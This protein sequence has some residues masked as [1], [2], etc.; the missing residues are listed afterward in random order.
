MLVPLSLSQCFPWGFK[1]GQGTSFGSGLLGTQV[2]WHILLLSIE[3]L[4][5]FSLSLTDNCHNSSN[6]LPY[7]FSVKKMTKIR[8]CA[9][10]R[11]VAQKDEQHSSN[12]TP[13]R[14]SQM[15]IARQIAIASVT[16]V[17]LA[18]SCCTVQYFLHVASQ[19]KNLINNCVWMLHHLTKSCNIF[20]MVESWW[21]GLSME[22]CRSMK[23]LQKYARISCTMYIQATR[24]C[25]LEGQRI[26]FQDFKTLQY[27]YQMS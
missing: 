6:W 26:H 20:Q 10:L 23:F 19:L 8:Y 9:F 24:A 13:N 4:Q 3:L 11:R 21:K 25:C 12:W 14:Y 16:T 7:N 22:A 18:L 15:I 5:V 27:R 1:F 2:Q 17:L